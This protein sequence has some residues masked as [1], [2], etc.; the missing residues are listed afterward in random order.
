[1]SFDLRAG[2]THALVGENGAGKSTL[3]KIFTGAITPDAGKISID[4]CAIENHTPARARELGIAAI[5]QHPALFPD[6]TVTEN[7]ALRMERRSAW[8]RV[9]WAERRRNASQLL[10]Q[11]GARIDPETRVQDLSMPEQQM[12]EIASALGAE[13]RIFIMDEP[14]AALASREVETLFTAINQ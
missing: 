8:T 13:A 1:V 10:Q 14:T 12:V 11:I 7:L 5:Y 4:D 6:L 3:I 2:E 9:R